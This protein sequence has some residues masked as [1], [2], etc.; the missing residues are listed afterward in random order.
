MVIANRMEHVSRTRVSHRRMNEG[1]QGFGLMQNTT[2]NF[3][4]CIDN[5][6]IR[7]SQICS[8]GS[9]NKRSGYKNFNML[10]NKQV[11]IHTKHINI[12]ASM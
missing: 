3:P 9:R 11:W 12:L 8:G 6:R 1:V 10:T 7:K 4:Y 5:A 2:Y